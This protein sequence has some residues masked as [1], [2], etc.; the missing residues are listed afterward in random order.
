MAGTENDLRFPDPAGGVAQITPNFSLPELGVTN[1]NPLTY[2]SS[3]HV[4]EPL[5]VLLEMLNETPVPS[6]PLGPAGPV[7]PTGPAGPVPPPPE[8]PSVQLVPSL[9]A[10]PCGPWGPVSPLGP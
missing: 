9:P 6:S 7:G 1:F 3:S 10:G 8:H 2:L 4:V 5:I